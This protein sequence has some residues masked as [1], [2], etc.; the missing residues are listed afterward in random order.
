VS[1]P[2]ALSGRGLRSL[3]LGHAI[4]PRLPTFPRGCGQR[5]TGDVACHVLDLLP[6]SGSRQS[7][8]R[9]LA[10]GLASA[11]A[12]LVTGWADWRDDETRDQRVGLAHAALNAS[13]IVLYRLSLRSRR[14]DRHKL[15]VALALGGSASVAAAGYLGAH[16]ITVRKVA[17]HNPGFDDPHVA[18]AAQA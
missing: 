14:Q 18:A 9:L 1:P 8:Q 10:I 16:L 12:A 2:P 7:A 17:S 4:H 6:V 13:G 5:R 11:P 3:G 15:G